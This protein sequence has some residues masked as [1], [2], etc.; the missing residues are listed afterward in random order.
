MRT[1]AAT[2]QGNPVLAKRAAGIFV[3]LACVGVL[4]NCLGISSAP[5]KTQAG[6]LALNRSALDFG[7][8]TASSSKIMTVTA[9]NS[10]EAAITIRGATVSTRSFSLA[11]PS[12]PLTIAA[13]QSAILSVEF[14]PSAPGT[15]KASL[16]LGSDPGDGVTGISLSGTGTGVTQ[17]QLGV[18][19]TTLGA[20]R[21]IVGSSGVASGSLTASGASVTVTG[22]ASSSSAFMIGGLSFPVTIQAGQSVPFMVTFSPQATGAASGTLTFTS[23]AQPSATVESLLGTGAAAPTHVVNLFWNA[24]AAPD[25]VGYNIYRAAFGGS[26]G[27]FAKINPAL[28]TSTLYSDGTVAGG[29]SY[30]YATS[31]VTSSN[32]ESAYSNIVANVQIPA[33]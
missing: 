21:V 6:T 29:A 20:G 7:S 17:G 31:A 30:C 4:T 12:L 14:S 18:S 9:T 22:A 28:N 23:N 5:S 13:G 25:T 32:Q 24:S 8:V 10:S 27:S 3:L 11:G 33:P 16:A 2:I 26:C 1:G 19:P 15:F